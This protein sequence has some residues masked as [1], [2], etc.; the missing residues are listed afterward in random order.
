M[1]G[2]ETQKRSGKPTLDAEGFQRLL[3]AAYILQSRSQ[4]TVWPIG[5][6]DTNAF[7]ATV[8][9]QKRTP[10]IRALSGRS[11]RMKEANIALQPTGLMFWKQVEAFGIAV[12]FCLMMGMSIHRLLASSGRASQ[13][14]GMLETRDAGPRPSSAPK[15]LTSS[16]QN[17]PAQESIGDDLVIYYRTPTATTRTTAKSGARIAIS[18]Q[19]KLAPH[20]V[21]QYGDDVTMWSSAESSPGQSSLGQSRKSFLNR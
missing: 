12:V 8:I 3:A 2:D 17:A 10:A 13:V 11:G 6:A 19:E 14:P 15:V 1:T 9:H 4:T 21:V 5:V 20:R 7:A 18:R 16:Q